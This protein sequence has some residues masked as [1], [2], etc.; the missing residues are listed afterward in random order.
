MGAKQG[1]RGLIG[2]IPSADPLPFHWRHLRCRPKIAEHVLR[3]DTASPLFQELACRAQYSNLF[4]DGRGDEL[5]QGDAVDPGKLR[6]G[7]LDRGWEFQRERTLAHELPDHLRSRIKHPHAKKPT[8]PRARVSEELIEKVRPGRWN[9]DRHPVDGEQRDAL[10]A[11]GYWQAFQS[12]KKSIGKVPGGANPGQVADRDHVS[13]YRELFGPSVAA[14]ILEPADLAGYRNA[15]VF[16]RRSMHTPPAPEAI[17][18]L[19]PA[20]FEL[21]EAEESPAVRVVLG[22]FMFVHIHPYADGNGRMGRFLMNV[23]AAA[24][25]Y[26]WIIVPLARRTDY[27]AALESASVEGNIRPFA[28]FLAGLVAHPLRDRQYPPF[29]SRAT[30][31]ALLHP[32]TPCLACASAKA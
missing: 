16:I 17:R 32:R 23:M 1:K 20:F 28:R 30:R 11:R 8:K 21:L 22:H 27:M 14:G 19:M 26:P 18:D 25:G 7:I 10:A 6:S 9:P 15:P 4:R 13:W 29:R 31:H 3:C 2:A 24:G 12:V 5:I